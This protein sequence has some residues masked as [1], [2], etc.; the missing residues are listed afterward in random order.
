MP[1]TVHTARL[2]SLIS[3]SP[4]ALDITRRTA[5]TA[6]RSG[7]VSPGAPWAPPDWLLWTVKGYPTAL[8]RGV[9][10]PPSQSETWAWYKQHF[11]AEMRR[12]WRTHHDAWQALLARP[13][14][15]LLCFCAD[16][17]QCHRGL[18]AQILVKCGAIDGG[19]LTGKGK[20]R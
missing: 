20:S 13:R 15:V 9:Q 3:R 12:S 4:D 14:V 5:R 8:P 7:T 6:E 16:R 1:L 10:P 2:G 19:E 17:E 11:L 18:V